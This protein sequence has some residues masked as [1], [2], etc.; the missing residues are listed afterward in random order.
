VGNLPLHLKVMTFLSCS[1]KRHDAVV[2]IG[3]WV[4][5]YDS[6]SEARGHS[7]KFKLRSAAGVLGS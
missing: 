1:L 6:Q 4:G 5:V 7:A 2:P 3:V